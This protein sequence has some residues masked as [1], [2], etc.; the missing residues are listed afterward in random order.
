M[1]QNLEDK[2]SKLETEN[3]ELNVKLE[4]EFNEKYSMKSALSKAD[5]MNKQLLKIIEN[6]SIGKRN[7]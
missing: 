2:I 5:D 7:G 1:E 4:R 6:L 3:R